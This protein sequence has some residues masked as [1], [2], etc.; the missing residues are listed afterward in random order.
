MLFCAGNNEN[1]AFA[2][3]I[4]IGMVQSA[5]NLSDFIS[6]NKVDEIVFVGTCGLYK[7][8]NLLEIYESKIATNHEISDI[9]GLS[10]SPLDLSKVSYETLGLIVNSSNF[11]TQNKEIAYK[12]AKLGYFMENMEFYGVL[13]VAKHHD[14]PAFGIFCATNF[15]DEN[16]HES[17][18]RN[19]AKAKEK[20]EIYIKEK[21][22]I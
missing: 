20:L 16:A 4:G 15:C 5:I 9:L 3:A 12:F 11:I 6:K 13:E 7:N 1:F 10:Y 22:L 17:F 19:H 18:I 8:G 21:G 2:K 14:I